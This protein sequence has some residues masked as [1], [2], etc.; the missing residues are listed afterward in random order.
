MR[1]VVVSEIGSQPMYV[2][3][4]VAPDG[5]RIDA[6]ARLVAAAPSF[7]QLPTVLNVESVAPVQMKFAMAERSDTVSPYFSQNSTRTYEYAAPEMFA[8]SA[9]PVLSWNVQSSVLS[10]CPWLP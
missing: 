1:R 8:M 5:T 6:L 2:N 3:D 9:L 10:P 7:A 4:C